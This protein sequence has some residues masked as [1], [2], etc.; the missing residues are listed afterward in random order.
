ML[1]GASANDERAA[2]DYSDETSTFG[3]RL[4][5]ARESMGMT[6]AQL[7]HRLGVKLQT[8]R[9][10]EEDRSEPRANK[11]QMVAGMLNTS[12]VWLMSGQGA[13]PVPARDPAARSEGDDLLV[14]LRAIRSDFVRLGERLGRFQIRLDTLRS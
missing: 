1:A 3:D 13:A 8:L 5:A 2:L 4:V 11:L 10:W 6:Q 9:N 14:E 7:A 12:M